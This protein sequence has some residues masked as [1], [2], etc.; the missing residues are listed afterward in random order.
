MN[1]IG[2]EI[3][4][5]CWTV[6]HLERSLLGLRLRGYFTS[7]TGT[8][9]EKAAFIKKML[10]EAGATEASITIGLDRFNSITKVLTLPA[11]DHESVEHMLKFEI[12]KHIPFSINE[13]NYDCQIIESKKGTQTVAL[14][15]TKKEV[16]E[17]VFDVLRGAGLEPDCVVT[18]KLALY[19]TLRYLKKVPKDSGLIF[20]HANNDLV[21]IETYGA[22]IP[23]DSRSI[24]RRDRGDW[25]KAVIREL[26]FAELSA[27]AQT[28][29]VPSQIIFSSEAPIDESIIS[30][31][32]SDIET[33]LIVDS[34]KLPD[35]SVVKNPVSF[36]LALRSLEKGPLRLNIFKGLV[37]KDSSTAPLFNIKYAATALAFALVT[38]V[39]YLIQDRL[40]LTRLDSAMAEIQEKGDDV[41]GLKKKLKSIEQRISAVEGTD[42]KAFESLN[43]LNGLAA[44]MPK[45]T[46]ITGFDFSETWIEIEGYSEQAS[47]LLISLEQSG[48]VKE[49]EFSGPVTKTTDGKEHFRLKAKKKADGG[50]A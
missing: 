46:W 11:P 25:I 23:I 18:D 16:T 35:G 19:N 43:I 49:V 29:K 26:K 15:I 31:L 28:G 34:F 44:N 9:S 42:N 37:K 33:P 24:K 4:K 10:T 12:E 30:A 20:V 40:V 27:K 7:N 47:G 21:A 50:R 6:T 32:K 5:N 1:A 22:R 2:I 3:G 8:D 17:K 48:I 13:A 45:G 38:G 14:G 41:K 39:S 36:G